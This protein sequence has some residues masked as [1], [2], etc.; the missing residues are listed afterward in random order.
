MEGLEGGDLA[1]GG[2]LCG[3]YS[4]RGI[5]ERRFGFLLEEM[6]C[7][8]SQTTYDILVLACL[9]FIYLFILLPLLLLLLFFLFFSF[10]FCLRDGGR[11]VLLSWTASCGGVV[12]VGMSR[13][14]L[15]CYRGLGVTVV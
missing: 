15:V 1:W 8:V 9:F 11:L 14:Y 13:R 2:S 5:T 10:D 7:A 4:V 12:G 6:L 3:P